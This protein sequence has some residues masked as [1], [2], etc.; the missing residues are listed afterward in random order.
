MSPKSEAPTQRYQQKRE[1]V[2]SQAALLFN[3]Q[4]LKSA[5]LASIAEG[6]GLATN[7]LTYYYR[8]KEDLA[9]ACLLR[10]AAAYDQVV[11]AALGHAQPADRLRAY[12]QGHVAL[13]AAIARGDHPPL[14]YF[15]DTR[16][17][18][19]PQAKQVFD[20]YADLFRHVRDVLR[21]SH[22]PL[23]RDALNARAHVLLSVVNWMG[24]WL[25][26]AYEVDE[27]LR[28]AD[29]IA[30]LLIHGLGATGRASQAVPLITG[31]EPQP[32][33]DATSE[34]FLRTA[35]WLLNE[36]GY[37]GASVDNIAAHLNRS[38]GAFYHHHDHK[39]DL[40]AA[41]FERTFDF[42]RQALSLAQQAPGPGLDRAYSAALAITQV[43]VSPQGPLLYSSAFS[44]LPS[45]AHRLQASRALRKLSSRITALLVEGLRDGSVRPLDGAMAAQVL[46]AGITGGAVLRHWTA[47]PEAAVELFVRPM[48]DGLLCPPVD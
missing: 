30:D 34:A 29:G 5:T 41:C 25:L 47:K 48:F 15:S 23:V 37:R 6:V 31:W 26:E 14:M 32:H 9:Q 1:V 3:E 13:L 27:Y 22:L 7:S 28:V 39:Q 4:G 11:V 10:S 42:M 36:H 18:P 43:Q 16:A 38:K 35:T 19:G 44:A 40:I 46:T 2:L 21:A 24:P 8:K 20:A 17:L 45:R 33:A 12:L